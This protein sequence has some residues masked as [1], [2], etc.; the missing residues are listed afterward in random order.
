MKIWYNN[1]LER[2]RHFVDNLGNR[3]RIGRSPGNDIVL[4]SPYAE[5]GML[6][7][8]PFRLSMPGGREQA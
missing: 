1:I 2:R 8:P 5:S 4:D 7:V 3:I 6:L